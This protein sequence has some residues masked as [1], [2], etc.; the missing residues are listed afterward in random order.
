[1]RKPLVLLS[2]RSNGECNMS[3]NRV[4]FDDIKVLG[5]LKTSHT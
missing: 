1:M 4:K 5:Q 3:R 2:D